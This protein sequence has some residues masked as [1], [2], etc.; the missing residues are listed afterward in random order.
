[1]VKLRQVI[2]A[3]RHRVHVEDRSTMSEAALDSLKRELGGLESAYPDLITPDSPSQRVA[4]A[5]LEK[6]NKVRHKVRQWSFNDAFTGE[7]MREFDARVRR[8]AKEATGTEYSSIP[9]TCELKIDG[10]KIVLTY[11]EGRLATAATRG[12]GE[13][14]EDVTANVRTIES[15]PL[16]LREP[17]DVIVTGEIWMGKRGLEKLNR[18]R[19]KAG[20]ERYMNPRN[21]AAGTIRH[22]DPRIV[23]TRKLSSFIY[24]IETLP[25]LDKP[26]GLTMS[27]W[28]ATQEAELARL[29]SLGFKVNPH[30]ERVSDI[31]GVIA[32]WKRWQTRKEKEDYFID[33]IVA[34]VD[35]Q[36]LQELIGYTGKAPRFAIAFKFPAEQAT[37]IVEDIKVQVGRTGK[38]TPVAWLAPVSVYGSTVSRATLHNEDEIKR[39]DVRVGDTVVLQ[40]AGD[41]IPQVVR[42][43]R[44]L[45]PANARSFRF[46]HV[47]PLCG[48]AV[49]RGDGEVA[50]RCL[51]KQCLATS[52]RKLTY[53]ASKSAFDIAGLGPKI[54]DL[55]IE[56]GLVSTP[57]DFF[58]L[59]PGDLAVLPGLG[60]RSA[61][62]LVSAIKEKRTIDLGRFILAL[63]ILH[64]GEE[65]AGD[66]ADHFGTMDNFRRAD[67]DQLA[68]VAGVGEVVARS[69]ADYF[70]DP[71]QRRLV[72]DL[73]TWV[74]P[75]PRNPRARPRGAI[76][77]KTFVLTGT[78]SSM[79]RDEAKR[80][81]REGG[82]TVS[83]AVSGATDYL[84]AGADP[85][86]K[87]EKAKKLG[88]ATIDEKEFLR[89]LGV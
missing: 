38:L 81:I 78:L 25:H 29:K 23:A 22:L 89:L 82:G 52:R 21:F 41:V 50:H 58:A 53:F 47:C 24:D 62:K 43:V 44:E 74:T 26:L 72:D 71:G 31:E 86:S 12:N 63:G 87:Q 48:S 5:P 69:V 13:V 83:S 68:T 88:V 17:V 37:T 66:L 11:K 9:Y 20:E 73:L 79:S 67:A 54:V 8:F 80:R 46:P 34:K 6:F 15:I 7:E 27:K 59:T 49:V 2:N 32:Y 33:G 35:E 84:V 10:F 36:R 40:K 75:L 18:E 85:G 77:G 57:A 55:L 60:A 70:A 16:T 56:K 1:M 61:E 30:H 39:L 42:V 19:E 4:G 76:V 64:V 14:G 51:N 45:R 65:T 3:E 28:P